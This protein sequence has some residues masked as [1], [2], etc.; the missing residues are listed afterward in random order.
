MSLPD[1]R[2]RIIAEHYAKE[3][4]R[5]VHKTTVNGEIRP[6]IYNHLTKGV[7]KLMPNVH[8]VRSRDLDDLWDDL[9]ESK[10]FAKV[11]E[12]EY[13]PLICVS[14]EASSLWPFKDMDEEP[15]QTTFNESYDYLNSKR[16]FKLQGHRLKNML[17]LETLVTAMSSDIV[18]APS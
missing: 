14:N 9:V 10:F 16:V 3:L 11:C 13:L 6:R 15:L 8:G 18:E 4:L 5:L 2:L 1:G 17:I 12:K 7:F